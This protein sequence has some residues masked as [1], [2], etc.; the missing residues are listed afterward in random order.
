MVKKSSSTE[1][2]KSQEMRN[3]INANPSIKA[4][5]AVAH[6]REKGIKSNPGLFYA[7]KG[8]FASVESGKLLRSG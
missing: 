7:V 6:L 1:I 3:L 4:S 2:N 8:C 5:E